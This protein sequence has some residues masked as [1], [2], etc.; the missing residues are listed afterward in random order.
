MTLAGR[1]GG[2]LVGDDGAEAE[3]AVERLRRWPWWWKGLWV[4]LDLNELAGEGVRWRRSSRAVV[5]SSSSSSSL[6]DEGT[7]PG[8]EW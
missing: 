4:M 3:A 6:L 1:G 7:M 5:S 8:A 2:G